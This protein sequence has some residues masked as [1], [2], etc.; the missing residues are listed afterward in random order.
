MT[1]PYAAIA[2][3]RHWRRAAGGEAGGRL[4]PVTATG[5]TIDRHAP[6]ATA[7]SCFAQHVMPALERAGVATLVTEA[8]PSI[9]SARRAR[10]HHYGVFTTRSGNVYTARQ[11]RQLLARAFGE[12]EPEARAWRRGDAFVDPFRPGVGTFVSEGELLRDR[13]QHLCAVRQMVERLSVMVF[14]LG[15]TEAWAD[16]D[17]AVFPIA[18]GVAG[19][20]FDG[21][22]HS[23]H[24]FSV[25]ETVADMR[26]AIAAVRARNP[27]ARFILTVSPVPLMATAVDRHVLVSTTHA[28]AVLRIAAGI[29][30]DGEEGVDY[31]PAY[32]I[33]TAPQ[34]R[35]RYF[36]ADARTITG[37]GVAHV[38]DVF[39][40]HYCP[41]AA[42]LS[43]PPAAAPREDRVARAGAMVNAL[44]DEEILRNL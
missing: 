31:F 27:S 8:P 41:G 25:E 5:F 2:D 22:R 7:G 26:A 16:A 36:A 24:T 30:A 20:T 23:L 39:L 43:S 3:Y 17:G 15:L 14:T 34:I 38:M 40:R 29:L 18:P 33:V 35:G 12:F 13:E 4:D 42:A 10:E 9:L 1:H 11:L 37:E 6:V 32:E 19:G 28:K 21:T 44:C